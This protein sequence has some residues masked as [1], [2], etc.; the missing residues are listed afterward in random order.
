MNKVRK[1]VIYLGINSPPRTMKDSLQS[2][3]LI[4]MSITILSCFTLSCVNT[5]KVT[6]FQ[7]MSASEI[8][9]ID[10]VAKF[11]EPI[12]QIDD[13]LSVNIITVDPQSV[14][15]VNQATTLQAIGTSTSP[16]RQEITG[17]P[18]DRN[19]DIELALVGKIHVAGLTTYQAKELVREKVSKDFKD[20]NVNVRF[21]NF[22]ISVL[23]EVNKPASY[24]LQNEKVSI[25][26][27][28]SLAGDLTIYGK[29]ENIAVIRDANGKKEIGRLNINSVELFSSPFYYLRQN[30]IIYVEP[31]KAKVISLN[32]AARTTAAVAVSALS[33]LVLIFTRIW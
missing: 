26:D 24:T 17:F 23:G 16:T 12:I 2:N 14:E 5:K 15:I 7:N 1:Y 25:L 19:G 3:K 10:S 32:A 21:A 11:A 27:V 13:I 20:P 31:N 18:V 30:D 4:L 8:S 33:T 29:R 6:Y 9:R 22:K 28:L